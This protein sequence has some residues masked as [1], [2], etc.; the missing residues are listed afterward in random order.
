LG[1]IARRRE[2]RVHQE[3]YSDP[4]LHRRPIAAGMDSIM[5]FNVKRRS[6]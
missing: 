1:L 5:A 2:I 6:L 4:T 3:F